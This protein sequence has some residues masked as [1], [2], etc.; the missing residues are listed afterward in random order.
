M[1]SAAGSVSTTIGH[2]I[3]DLDSF[4]TSTE[5]VTGNILD[6]T[7]SAAV[8]DTLGSSFTTVTVHNANNTNSYTLYQDGDITNSSGGVVSSSTVTLQGHYGTLTLAG[9]GSY[10]YQ[11][12]AGINLSTITS[13]ESFAY[14]LTDIDGHT[15]NSNLTIELHPDITGT[16]GADVVHGTVYEDTL[17][18]NLLDSADATGG[19]GMDTWVDF[20]ITQ[21]DKI[22]VS[23]LLDS[24]TT[25][26]ADPSNTNYI[27]HYISVDHV[28]NAQ[29]GTDTVISIDRD[30][31]ALTATNYS[32]TE[33]LTLKNTDTTLEQLLNNHQLLY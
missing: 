15:S 26:S 23:A 32:A 33:L 8:S 19:N 12:N 6:G 30:G 2:Q 22:D 10:S 27:G 3:Y 24:S 1:L 13:K 5:T 29:G 16:V 18:Y 11:L 9:D 28:T 4:V 14:T 20:S 31:D 7:D 25:Y 21:G 17:I